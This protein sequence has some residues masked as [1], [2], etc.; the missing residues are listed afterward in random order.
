MNLLLLVHPAA[1]LVL[2]EHLPTTTLSSGEE[3]EFIFDYIMKSI[4]SSIAYVE[5]ELV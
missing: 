2:S 1:A 5:F 3:Y 4:S